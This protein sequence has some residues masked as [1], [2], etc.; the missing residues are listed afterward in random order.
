M[1][2]S[3]HNKPSATPRLGAEARKNVR[4]LIAILA[5]SPEPLRLCEMARCWGDERVDQK[6]LLRCLQRIERAGLAYCVIRPAGARRFGSGNETAARY[7]AY[8]ATV[9]MDIDQ[10]VDLCVS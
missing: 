6:Y 2:L 9:C 1:S 4:R 7:R 10:A 3:L 8:P 5:A